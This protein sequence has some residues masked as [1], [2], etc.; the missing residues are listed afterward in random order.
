ML[1][2]GA[3]GEPDRLRRCTPLSSPRLCSLL[4]WE[5]ICLQLGEWD[6]KLTARSP[7][8]P[9]RS[10]FLCYLP[11]V[12]TDLKA[13]PR[14]TYKCLRE[15]GHRHTFLS[16]NGWRLMIQPTRGGGKQ[17]HMWVDP[18]LD[19]AAKVLFSSSPAHLTSP[20]RSF[21]RTRLA[22]TR[23]LASIRSL[24]LAAPAYQ[25]GKGGSTHCTPDVKEGSKLKSGIHGDNVCLQ[26]SEFWIL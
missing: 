3:D 25:T 9:P 20:A 12:Y 24:S 8:R 6:S 13:H 21:C 4:K 11:D 23:L 26:L 17:N 18:L 16:L 19:L 10:I 5:P 14:H 7:G 1:W 2:G 15:N 22:K